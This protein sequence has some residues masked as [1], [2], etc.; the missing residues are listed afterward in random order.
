MPNTDDEEKLRVVARKK[1]R[2]VIRLEKIQKRDYKPLINHEITNLIDGKEDI[3]EFI[4][5]QRLG[6]FGFVM[7]TKENKSHW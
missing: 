4:N 7:Y 2:K 5:A 1:L 6:W 3:V